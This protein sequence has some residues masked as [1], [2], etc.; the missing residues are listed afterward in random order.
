MYMVTN[1]SDSYLFIYIIKTLNEST[2]NF[3]FMFAFV[4]PQLEWG[5]SAIAITELFKEMLLRNC[6]YAIPQSQFFNVLQLYLKMT[7]KFLQKVKNQAKS[8]KLRLCQNFRFCE[9][10]KFSRN[11]V[12]LIF[13][14]NFA[15]FSLQY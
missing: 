5:T 11:F 2:R 13:L 6:N 14:R 3:F 7:L 1:R 12:F 4:I 15:E 10:H 8:R 9:T